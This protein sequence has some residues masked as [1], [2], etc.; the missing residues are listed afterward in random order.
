MTRV[1]CDGRRDTN[2][3]PNHEDAPAYIRDSAEAGQNENG[4]GQEKCGDSHTR[5]R[6]TGTS[7]ESD[8]TTRNRDKEET[9]YDDQCCG[10]PCGVR[11]VDEYHGIQ[12]KADQ[13]DEQNRSEEENEGG[14]ILLSSFRRSGATHQPADSFSETFENEGNTFNQAEDASE[15]NSSGTDVP[16][17]T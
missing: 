2:K 3:G 4:T 12:K 7:Q 1:T 13:G 9:E 16:D 11:L 15:G 10:N 8:D 6:I 17:V 5:N 14:E